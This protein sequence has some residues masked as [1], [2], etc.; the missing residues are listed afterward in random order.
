MPPHYQMKNGRPSTAVALPQPINVQPNSL[1]SQAT[2]QNDCVIYHL[3]PGYI[4]QWKVA[5]L[6]DN[7]CKPGRPWAT[8]THSHYTNPSST[9]VNSKGTY[10]RSLYPHHHHLP[11]QDLDEDLP[12]QLPLTEV[13]LSTV[14]PYYFSSVFI[15]THLPGFSEG[16]NH[17]A[18]NLII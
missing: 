13:I 16:R 6:L 15:N 12:F 5:L 14:T 11:V 1:A 8:W 4:W 3:K 7:S 10:L 9:A 17:V 18:N 2:S